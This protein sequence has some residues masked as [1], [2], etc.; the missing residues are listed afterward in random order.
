M[1]C[2]SCGAKL[3]VEE[4]RD[5]FFCEYCGARVEREKQRYELSGKVTIDGT[6]SEE[7]LLKRAFLFIESG[8]FDKGSDYINKVLDINPENGKAYI[9]QLL[10]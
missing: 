7:S 9:G 5:V 3:N 4:T 1:V 10:C 6:A 8:E 2:P